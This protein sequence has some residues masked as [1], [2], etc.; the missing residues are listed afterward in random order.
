MD[1]DALSSEIGKGLQWLRKSLSLTQYQLASFT[2]LDYRHYQNIETGRVE[3]KVETLKRICSTF[4]IGL[5][6]FFFILDRRPWLTDLPSKAKSGGELYLFRVL[7]EQACFRVIPSVRELLSK[8][9]RDLAEGSR[10]TLNQ[11][12]LPCVE[13]DLDLRVLW[14]N[15]AASRAWALGADDEI[16]IVELLDTKL[17]RDEVDHFLGKRANSFYLEIPLH[18][19]NVESNM[20]F[21]VVGLRPMLAKAP[22][23][24]FL[25]FVKLSPEDFAKSEYMRLGD[26]NVASL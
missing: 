24:I 10:D 15:N 20:A 22:Q 18:R 9:G 25:A 1:A 26:R 7:L 8:W 19:S 23:N 17:I 12:L 16:S 2:E 4:G 6:T 11:L 3:V 5:S 21:A 13:T 14:K